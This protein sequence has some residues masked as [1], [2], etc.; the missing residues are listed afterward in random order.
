MKTFIIAATTADGF[1]GRDAGHLADWTGNADK[2]LFVKLTKEAGVV[3]MGSRTFK[4]IG[5]ALPG[6]RTIVYT[7]HPKEITAEG[8][9]TTSEKPAQLVDRL[10]SEG[11]NGVAICGGASIYKLFMEA[12]VVD[13]L[14]ITVI[15]KLFGT[16]VP[17]FGE[18][19]DVNLMLLETEKL[20]DKSVLLHYKVQTTSNESYL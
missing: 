8:V 6:R 3:I 9:E 16:G 4:T 5:R 1:I 7:H 13:E 12:G 11:A 15:G 10:K 20:N 17:L 18:T 14:Y 19:L 2:K